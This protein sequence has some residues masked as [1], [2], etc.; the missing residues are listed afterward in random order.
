LYEKYKAGDDIKKI[1]SWL[2]AAMNGPVLENLGV[3]DMGSIWAGTGVGL[4]KKQGTAAKIIKEISEDTRKH[5]NRAV[6]SL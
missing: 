4:V 6:V 2:S 5:L 1:R 3:K